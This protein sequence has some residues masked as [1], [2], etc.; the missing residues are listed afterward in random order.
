MYDTLP[1]VGEIIYVT[2]PINMAYQTYGQILS[3]SE[4]KC[5]TLP[6]IEARFYAKEGWTF[7]EVLRRNEYWIIGKDTY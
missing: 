4:P 6:N 2:N 3:V 5:G 1:E 7:T